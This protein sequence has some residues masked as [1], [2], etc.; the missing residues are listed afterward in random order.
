M[1]LGTLNNNPALSTLS[2]AKR[3]QNVEDSKYTFFK[4]TEGEE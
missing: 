2:T 1:P 3:L 4:G